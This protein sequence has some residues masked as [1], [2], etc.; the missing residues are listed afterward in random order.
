[1]TYARSNIKSHQ[2]IY[3]A[4]DSTLSKL[5]KYPD[6]C[7]RIWHQQQTRKHHPVVLELQYTEHHSS[8]FRQL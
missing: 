5:Q 7:L 3:E 2:Y 6:R 1:M 4:L 8:H